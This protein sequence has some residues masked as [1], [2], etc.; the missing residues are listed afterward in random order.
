MYILYQDY[1]YIL[2]CTCPQ[3]RVA[4]AMDVILDVVRQRGLDHEGQARDVDAPCRHVGADE[5]AHVALLKGLQVRAA[6]ILV[7]HARQHHAGVGVLLARLHL[8]AIGL[9]ATQAVQVVLQVVALGAHP[10]SYL[11]RRLGPLQSTLV[12]QKTRH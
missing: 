10:M 8:A 5:E 11:V 9:R 6:L 4:D 1:N 7:P 2:Q 12:L 3:R